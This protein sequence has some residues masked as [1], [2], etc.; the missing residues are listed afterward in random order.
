MVIQEQQDPEETKYQQPLSLQERLGQ[1][2]AGIP[3][4]HYGIICIPMQVTAQE[5]GPSYVSDLETALLEAKT[6]SEV[7]GELTSGGK[8]VLRPNLFDTRRYAVYD[9]SGTQVALYTSG[10]RYQKGN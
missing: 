1:Q 4:G 9:S 3:A 8:D 2:I 6:R 5:V 7:A 10:E